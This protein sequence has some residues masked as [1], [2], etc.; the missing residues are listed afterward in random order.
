MFVLLWLHGC[1]FLFCL[2]PPIPRSTRARHPLGLCIQH[3]S[4]GKLP[5]QLSSS[6]SLWAVHQ[7]L[8][9]RLHATGAIC[10]AVLLLCY[11]VTLMGTR[12]CEEMQWSFPNPVLSTGWK[13]SFC[14][15]IFNVCSCRPL[16]ELES[17][18]SFPLPEQCET[19]ASH[20]RNKGILVPYV[21][22][23]GCP[24]PCSLSFYERWMGINGFKKCT[25]CC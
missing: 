19:F 17:I 9:T 12:S 2:S 8:L 16:Q 15:Y 13:S 4:K 23:T 22:S 24:P 5:A 6:F 18:A 3:V 7:T 11:I 21:N 10:L 1:V 25:P 14:Q 20:L